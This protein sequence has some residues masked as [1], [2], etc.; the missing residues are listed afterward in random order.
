MWADRVY[1]GVHR[2]GPDVALNCQVP[3]SCIDFSGVK[4]DP[5][6]SNIEFK[7]S[8]SPYPSLHEKK[9]VVDIRYWEHISDYFLYRINLCEAVGGRAGVSYHFFS[10]GGKGEGVCVFFYL[11]K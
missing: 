9:W 7:M 8:Y 1:R 6:Q 11:I 3:S 2:S 4:L 10:F 5:I